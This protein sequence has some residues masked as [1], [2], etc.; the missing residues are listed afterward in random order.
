MLILLPTP[1]SR[2]LC[3]ALRESRP[4]EPYEFEEDTAADHKYQQIFRTIST[5]ANCTCINAWLVHVQTHIRLIGAFWG[6]SF[7]T[8]AWFLPIF[9]SCERA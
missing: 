3:A 7:L 9:A 5:H 1:P 4:D 8:A 6:F 2:Y